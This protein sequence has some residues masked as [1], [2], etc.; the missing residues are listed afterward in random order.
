MTTYRLAPLK[1]VAYRIT[2]L[3][4]CGVYDPGTC[5]MFASQSIGSIERT[6]ESADEVEF[7]LINANGDLEEYTSD[8]S[9]LKYQNLNI[10]LTK[11]VPE[12]VGWMTGGDVIYDDAATSS[13]VGWRVQTNASQYANYAFEFWTRLSG[14]ASCAGNA[15]YG[16]GIFPWIVRGTFY[17]VTHENA[18]SDLVIMGQTTTGSPWSTGPYSVNLSEA[19]AT[20]G[21]PM[22]MFEA[23]NAAEDHHLFQRTTLAP[24]AIIN[25]CRSVVGSLTV[26]DDDGAG[27]GLDATATIP[28]PLASTTP[29]YIDW[30]DTTV[31]AVASGAATA[32]HTY[33]AAGP[34]T[35]TYRPS[36]YS[37]VVYT[38]SVTM[39]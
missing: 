5:A 20:L 29:G 22:A 37:D 21:H 1:I 31:S 3:D 4:S 10:K 19:V 11:A 25:T 27:A 13:A 39:A 38:G 14:E 26:V 24:P 12:L 9:R 33:G 6:G 35:V 7:P 32:A 8:G 2:K 34:Y 18:L 36:A 15:A 28:T 23:V 17:E 16:Y 30:G